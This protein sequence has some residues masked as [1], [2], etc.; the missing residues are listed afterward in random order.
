MKMWKRLSAV[1]LALCVVLPLSLQAGAEETPAENPWTDIVCAGDVPWYWEAVNY[2]AEEGIVSGVGEGRF[3]PGRPVTR[4]EFVTFLGRLAVKQGKDLTL[5]SDGGHVQRLYAAG[6][7][8]PFAAEYVTWANINDILVGD[9]TGLRTKQTMTRQE[10]AAMLVRF[11]DYM[12]IELPERSDWQGDFEKMVCDVNQ[13]SSWAKADMELAYRHGLLNGSKR[14][15]GFYD[16]ETGIHACG[17]VTYLDP[18]KA[19]TRAEAA[20]VVYNYMLAAGL[21]A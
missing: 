18:Q 8:S 20:Q 19:V 12:G 11:A 14:L 15:G 9:G 17:M 6:T 1:V 3:Y 4:E 7:V 16:P 13:I 10:M 21:A 5:S 2:L